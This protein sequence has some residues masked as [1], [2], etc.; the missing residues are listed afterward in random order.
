MRRWISDYLLAKPKASVTEVH[1][2]FWR[3]GF[4]LSRTTLC[5]IM[6]SQRGPVRPIRTHMVRMVNCKRRVDFCV[7]MFSRLHRFDQL[8]GVHRSTPVKLRR[9]PTDMACTLSPNARPLT[10]FFASWTTPPP[11]PVPGP[12]RGTKKTCHSREG[13]SSSSLPLRQT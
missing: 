2:E 1:V 10:F 3:S 5:R 11:M 4:D 8:Q 9:V 12:R 13:T 7:D 6:H